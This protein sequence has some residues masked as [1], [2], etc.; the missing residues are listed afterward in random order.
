MPR[1]RPA[2]GEVLAE[3]PDPDPDPAG[4]DPEPTFREVWDE[5]AP[6]ARVVKGVYSIYKTE[7]GGM[8]IAYRPDGSEEDQHLPVP[9]AMM[10]MMLAASEGKG[11][12]GRFRALVGGLT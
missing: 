10:A 12:L 6:G 7:E 5:I 11:P 1:R 8:H 4:P 9:P 2:D 3:T